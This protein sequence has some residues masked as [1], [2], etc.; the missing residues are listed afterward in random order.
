ML[1]IYRDKRITT[2][3]YCFG[4][5]DSIDEIPPL[6]ESV[7][8]HFVLLLA[9]DATSIADDRLRELAHRLIDRGLAYL[10]AWGPDCE[11]VHDQFDLERDP[12]ETDGRVVMTTWHDEEPLAET[13]WEFANCA[14]PSEEFEVGCTDWVAIAVGNAD[15]G[16]ELRDELVAKNEGFPP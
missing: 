15:W 1:S 9:M 12:N 13:A 14:Y 11:R 4:A 8:P 2:R 5:A 6:I 3:R 10:C 7:S 16:R